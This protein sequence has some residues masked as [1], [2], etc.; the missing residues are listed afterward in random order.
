MMIISNR[1]SVSY[2]FSSYITILKPRSSDVLR[3]ATEAVIQLN[4]RNLICN[5]Q[6]NDTTR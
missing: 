1:A 6:T 5:V 3:Q 4:N 2:R